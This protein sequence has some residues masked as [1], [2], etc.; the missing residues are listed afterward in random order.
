MAGVDISL[1][2]LNVAEIKKKFTSRY[3]ENKNYKAEKHKESRQWSRFGSIPLGYK[4][5][6]FWK[7]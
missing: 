3:S 2:L 5:Y 6:C 1:H 7:P 4:T